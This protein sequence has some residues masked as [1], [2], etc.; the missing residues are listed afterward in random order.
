MKQISLTVRLIK[1]SMFSYLILLA[2][3]FIAVYQLLIYMGYMEYKYYGLQEAKAYLNNGDYVM[4]NNGVT[5]NLSSYKSFKDNVEKYDGVK[6][7]IYKISGN[8][9]LNTDKE[10]RGEFMPVKVIMYSTGYIDFYREK[11]AAGSYP[12]DSILN[13]K[14]QCVTNL[15]DVNVGDSFYIFPFAPNEGEESE[16]LGEIEITGKFYY[17]GK[18]LNTSISG[19]GIDL[20]DCYEY[21]E[22]VIVIPYN[23]IYLEAV[24]NYM[25]SAS[26]NYYIL[27]DEKI[28]DR[29][30][31]YIRE[32]VIKENF[33]I[34]V[35]EATEKTLEEKKNTG[36]S[37][38]LIPILTV[39][40]SATT[41]IVV[42]VISAC[43]YM[44]EFS[45]YYIV[46]GTKGKIMGIINP[47]M[48]PIIMSAII[49]GLI[50]INNYEKFEDFHA[51]RALDIGYIMYNSFI[52]N[53][54]I[55][56]IVLLFLSN[57]IVMAVI[58]RMSPMK[59]YRQ[60]NN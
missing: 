57:I 5:Y 43:K 36:R 7:V 24:K 53:I 33:Y 9:A 4:R 52:I 58:S 47:S 1:K 16:L 8:A 39:Y 38:L 34:S 18:F 44:K 21:N 54:I 12:K 3:I 14:Y 13:G 11:I 60:I 20:T 17:C 48:A 55:F 22:A 40:L 10:G 6:S 29:K 49:Y 23:E 2:L 19:N 27:Y 46:G 31:Q 56:L 41:F 59:F 15:N 42:S 51:D 50:L 32:Q 35:S 28:S 37:R 26:E 30:K 25:Y 45:V